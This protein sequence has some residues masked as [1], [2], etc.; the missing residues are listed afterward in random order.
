MLWFINDYQEMN[1][2]ISLVLNSEH[3][4]YKPIFKQID[5]R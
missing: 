3:D 4:F 2:K 5:S 1:F